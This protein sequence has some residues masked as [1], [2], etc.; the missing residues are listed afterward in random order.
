MVQP[1]LKQR[2]RTWMGPAVDAAK[3]RG[4]TPN[5]LSAVNLAVAAGI[6]LLLALFPGAQLPLLLLAPAVLARLGLDLLDGILARELHQASPLG[7]LL[8]DAAE[9]LGSVLL[10]LPVALHP[11]V[12]GWLVVLVVALGLCA[13]I[14]GLSAVQIDGTRRAD[15]PFG[16]R[17]RALLFALIGAI[18]ALDG[19]AA[20]W[21]P[22]LLLPALILTLVTITNRIR[23]A[24][25]G[26][27]G[28]RQC[29][30]QGT[31]Q[32]ST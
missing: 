8:N 12:A 20:P 1:M 3:A 19:D 2:I 32:R 10:Y 28:A 9:A 4:V 22:W 14:I 16:K 15:G 13:E 30:R 29:P 5:Q 23:L 31:G 17:D 26:R 24:Q 18:L 27:D 11:G 7:T 25:P 6:G 21:L